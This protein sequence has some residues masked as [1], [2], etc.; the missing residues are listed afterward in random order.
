[1]DLLGATTETALPDK[2][3]AAITSMNRAA[4]ETLVD[5]AVTA[6]E[7]ELLDQYIT[8]ALIAGGHDVQ[9]FWLD[10]CT[11]HS[12]RP[13]IL[14]AAARPVTISAELQRIA[15][16]SGQPIPRKYPGS[17]VMACGRCSEPCWV[18]PRIRQAL[19]VNPTMVLM[20]YLCAAK[21]P[22]L[23]NANI[24]DLGNTEGQS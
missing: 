19:S 7:A 13:Q 9:R 14:L 24:H 2:V 1:V 17:V 10:R 8:A 21:D 5:T 6:G 11:C 15:N 18:G 12:G 23:G 22:E 4:L 16:K 3:L 20:C